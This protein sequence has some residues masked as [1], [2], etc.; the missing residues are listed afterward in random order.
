MDAK[1]FENYNGEIAWM[2]ASGRLEYPTASCDAVFEDVE[3]DH[4]SK[5]YSWRQF[6]RGFKPDGYFFYNGTFENEQAEQD[7]AD[8]LNENTGAENSNNILLITERGVPSNKDEQSGFVPHEAKSTDTM[9]VS[10]EDRV[11]RRIINIYGQPTILHGVDKPGA[12]GLQKEWEEAVKNYDDKTARERKNTLLFLIP[13]LNELYPA[14][15][16]VEADLVIIPVTGLEKQKDNR[17]LAEIIGVGGIT[18]MTEVLQSTLT[19]QQKINYLIIAFG[20]EKQTATALVLGTELPEA[21]A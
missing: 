15:N 8:N 11:K 19:D 7:F 9:Y 1:G 16:L 18:S 4:L 10:T 21:A 13:V 20:I 3:S 5:V 2:T 17:T 14:M 12:L 6:K